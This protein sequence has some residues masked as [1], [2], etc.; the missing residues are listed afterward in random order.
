MCFFLLLFLSPET[1][2][3]VADLEAR[4]EQNNPELFT[5]MQIADE[6]TRA[7]FLHMFRDAKQLCRLE[8]R[9]RWLAWRAGVEQELHDNIAAMH[10]DLQA[11]VKVYGAPAR[12]T[13]EKM[14]QQVTVLVDTLRRKRSALQA[15]TISQAA[16]GMT[17]SLPRNRRAL[18]CRDRACTF[19]PFPL[20]GHAGESC[21]CLF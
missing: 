6:E 1:K 13:V 19:D 16:K 15:T 17:L 4:L 9:K 20:R 7:N 11:D 18:H 3:Q 21:I 2:Q 8:A 5:M 14:L 12:A 10:A